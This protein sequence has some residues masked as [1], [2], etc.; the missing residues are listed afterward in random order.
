M[1]RKIGSQAQAKVQTLTISNNTI[2]D[3]ETGTTFDFLRPYHNADVT[4]LEGA[5]ALLDN[6]NKQLLKPLP[7][8]FEH[9]DKYQTTYRY[10]TRLTPDGK[11]SIR[12]VQAAE[13][14]TPGR[15]YTGTIK[16]IDIE[17][18]RFI[19]DNVAGDE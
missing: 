10:T 8:G 1:I 18:P 9:T 6:R 13:D 11:K 7:D 3:K 14:L 15:G 2:T 5:Q 16:I 4:Y 19:V 17:Q 12:V